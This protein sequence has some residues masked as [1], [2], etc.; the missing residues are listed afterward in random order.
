MKQDDDYFVRPDGTAAFVAS[1]P[2]PSDH[3][4]TAPGANEP[5]M[6]FRIGIGET[7]SRLVKEIKAA[8]RYAYRASSMNGTRGIDPDALVQNFVIGMIGYYTE[9]GFSSVMRRLF[10]EEIAGAEK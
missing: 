6:P 3:W 2:L 8:A 7:R 4:S 5:P 1:L 10:E 9:D